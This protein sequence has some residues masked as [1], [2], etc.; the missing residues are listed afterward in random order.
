MSHPYHKYVSELNKRRDATNHAEFVPRSFFRP[1]SGGLDF[2]LPH[3]TPDVKKMMKNG[4]NSNTDQDHYSISG[5]TID[6]DAAAKFIKDYFS[7]PRTPQSMLE[8]SLA[9]EHLCGEDDPPIT[10]PDMLEKFYHT[11]NPTLTL[12]SPYV[13]KQGDSSSS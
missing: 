8:H 11:S 5:G 10:D 2:R 6:H 4:H 3:T 7:G 12:V 13:V 1:R 9:Y